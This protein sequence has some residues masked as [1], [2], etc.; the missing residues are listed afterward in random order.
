M[1]MLVEEA[2][3]LA[4]GL[5]HSRKKDLNDLVA[6]IDALAVDDLTR[7]DVVTEHIRARCPILIDLRAL[8]QPV[9]LRC[10]RPRGTQF[11]LDLD[12]CTFYHANIARIQSD[13]FYYDN[14]KTGRDRLA[15]CG[16][17]IDG[18]VWTVHVSRNT[19]KPVAGW[20]ARV[21]VCGRRF[22]CS[23]RE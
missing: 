12:H 11:F 4:W 23:L 15:I 2:K 19:S 6:S 1:I 10:E 13:V 18:G 17:T 7:R 8:P 5:V 22:A 9:S 21:K 14:R 3:E 16:N 20:E